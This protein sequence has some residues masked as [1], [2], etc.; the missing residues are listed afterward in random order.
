MLDIWAYFPRAVLSFSQ[1]E[2][3]RLSVTSSHS[4][5]TQSKVL[6]VTGSGMVC[7]CF[8]EFS[9]QQMRLISFLNRTPE[10]SKEYWACFV[11]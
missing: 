2:Y 10:L 3:F 1:A 7:H 9:R 4:E 5:T 6:Q 11:R 8:F